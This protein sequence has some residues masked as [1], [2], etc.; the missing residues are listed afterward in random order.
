MNE[1]L[2]GGASSNS[3]KMILMKSKAIQTCASLVY[4]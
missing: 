2:R 4:A 1:M 3:V